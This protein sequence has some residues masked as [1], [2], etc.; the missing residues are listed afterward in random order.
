LA[1][2]DRSISSLEWAGILASFAGVALLIAM[3]TAGPVKLGLKKLEEM[4]F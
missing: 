2:E 3:A 1:A 4:D